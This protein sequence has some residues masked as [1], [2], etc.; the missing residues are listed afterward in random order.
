MAMAD[1][2]SSGNFGQ[3]VRDLQL[4]M[5]WLDTLATLLERLQLTHTVA[6]R[7]RK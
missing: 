6:S 5:K 7:K 2:N 4:L 3:T 1:N